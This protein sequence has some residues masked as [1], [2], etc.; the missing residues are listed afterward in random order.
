MHSRIQIITLGVYA[1]GPKKWLYERMLKDLKN[2]PLSICSRAQKMTLW[3]YIQGPKG[4]LKG[5]FFGSL[6]VRSK[7]YFLGPWAYAQRAIKGLKMQQILTLG[8]IHK[9]IW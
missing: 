6:S 4:I 3:V 9:K 7:G 5:S 1:K 8:K 2:N